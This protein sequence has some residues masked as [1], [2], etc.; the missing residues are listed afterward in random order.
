M[1]NK[2]WDLSE[3]GISEIDNLKRN[4]ENCTET[5]T[6]LGSNLRSAYDGVSNDLGKFCSLIEEELAVI[7]IINRNLE[8][9]TDEVGAKL[10]RIK[11]RIREFLDRINT[12][13]QNARSNVPGQ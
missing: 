5:M 9:S 7:D 4:V 3:E 2:K 1:S 11:S 13:A 6:A 8:S 10:E 12:E